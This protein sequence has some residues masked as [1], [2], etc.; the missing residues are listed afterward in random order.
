MPRCSMSTTWSWISSSRA[1]QTL[2]GRYDSCRA[3]MQAHFMQQMRCKFSVL[4]LKLLS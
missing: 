2:T 1:T 4:F 3:D